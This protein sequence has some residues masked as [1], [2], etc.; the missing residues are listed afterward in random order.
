MPARVVGDSGPPVMLLPGGAEATEG[1]FPGL[2]E[3]LVADPGCR[4]ILYDRPGTGTSTET[5][6]LAGAA[7]A[8]KAVVDGL[9]TGP[10]V[11]V[12]QSLGGAVATLLARDHPDVVAGVV[13]LD[14]TP[15]N[16]RAL[17]DRTLRTLGVVRTVTS[18]PVLGRVVKAGL[19]VALAR[20]RRN[21]RP[22]CAAAHAR[23][24]GFDVP[25]LARATEG[26]SELAAGFRE[27]DLPEI[28]SVVVTAERKPDDAVHRA[29]ARLAAAF[30]GSLVSWPKATHDVHL[31]H[32]DE[33]LRTVRDVVA[34]TA[35]T[36][37][38]PR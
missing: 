29:H 12:G 24:S 23:I 11:V 19:G 13:L 5:G 33:T 8:L 3:G 21:L 25:T 30:G 34:R 7:D 16:D 10:V 27:S 20:Q 9:G 35:D 31:T 17:C 22:D 36:G 2:V 37:E 38:E 15:V 26:L 4:V 28:P 14:P 18:L 1:F 6:S 32:P